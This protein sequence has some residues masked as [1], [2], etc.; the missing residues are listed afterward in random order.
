MG[1][2]AKGKMSGRMSKT[3]ISSGA[4]VTA[5][6][7]TA[8]VAL[9]IAYHPSSSVASVQLSP[10]IVLEMPAGV[11]G[12]TVSLP[13]KAKFDNSHSWGPGRVTFTMQSPAPYAVFNSITNNPN[14]GDERNF[15][16][17]HD[18]EDNNWQDSLVAQDGHTYTCDIYFDNDVASNLDRGNL[19]AQ[20]HNARARAMLPPKSTYNPGVVGFL[21]AANAVTVWSTCNFLASRPMTI[22]YVRGTTRMFTFGTPKDG[23]ALAENHL[24]ATLTDGLTGSSGTPIGYSKQ[25]GIARQGGGYILFDIKINLVPA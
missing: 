18:K 14:Q 15:I 6:I 22:T 9:L 16:Q 8:A 20:M 13:P 3:W 12:S 7:I 5:A 10:K 24:G 19:A 17:C 23:L 1:A 4:I 2:S 25:D 11:P 21:S